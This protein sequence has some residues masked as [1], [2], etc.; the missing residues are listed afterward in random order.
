MKRNDTI[1]YVFNDFDGCGCIEC[2]I[3]EIYNDHIIIEDDNGIS[4][5]IYSEEISTSTRDHP[6]SFVKR[7]VLVPREQF[8][9]VEK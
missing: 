5:W 4:Y 9:E 2:K 1:Y 3:K 8:F 6:I 7:T